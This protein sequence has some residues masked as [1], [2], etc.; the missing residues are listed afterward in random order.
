MVS[1][2]RQIGDVEILALDAGRFRLDGGAMFGVVPRGLWEKRTTPDDRNRI[3]LGLTCLL[4]RTP[5]GTVL[6]ET[7]HGGEKLPA[8][9]QE[10]YALDAP[11]GGILGAL[12]DAGVQADEVD[13]VVVSHLHPDHAG[14]ATRLDGDVCVPSFPKA[15]YVVQRAEW[16]DALSDEPQLVKAYRAKEDLQP[17]R[18]SGLLDLVDGETGILP[19][20]RTL[21]TPGH[22]RAHQSVLVSAGDETICFVG[23]LVPTRAHLRLPYIMSFDLYPKTTFEVKGELL[24]RAVRERWL[25]VWP[26]DTGGPWGYVT[27]DREGE[28]ICEEDGFDGDEDAVPARAG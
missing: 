27:R 19:G 6:V 1:G 28:F 8:K 7:G 16:E 14:G 3:A 15:R 4:V 24:D 9:L 25:V 11:P 13:C 12:A 20:V 2:H 10:I 22:T 26:H 5:H 21:A 17:L 18:D 23:D